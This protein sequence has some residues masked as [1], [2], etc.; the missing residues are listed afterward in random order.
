MHNPIKTLDLIPSA[1]LPLIFNRNLFVQQSTIRFNSNG[2]SVFAFAVMTTSSNVLEANGSFEFGPNLDYSM[3]MKKKKN[4]RHVR[5][6]A[7]KKIKF[8]DLEV[9]RCFSFGRKAKKKT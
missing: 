8:R 6:E 5:F 4:E 9:D 7:I 2:R 3:K 1:A